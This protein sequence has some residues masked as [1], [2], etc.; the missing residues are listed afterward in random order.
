MTTKAPKT[1]RSLNLP[2]YGPKRFLKINPR[3]IGSNIRVGSF[4][5]VTLA[6]WDGSWT[7]D[8]FVY[9]REIFQDFSGSLR[10]ILFCHKPNKSRHIAAFMGKIED[11]LKLKN[12]SFFGPTQRYNVMWIMPSQWWM[13]REIKRSL[14]TCLLRCGWSYDPLRNNFYEAL[15]SQQYTSETKYAVQRFLRGYT[16]YTGSHNYAYDQRIGWHDT[17][18]WGGCRFEEDSPFAAAL[19]KNEINKLLRKPDFSD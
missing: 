1:V 14:F 7:A 18:R 11:K 15:W 2:N 6:A 13:D 4:S 10:R 19:S 17:F 5:A 8:E 9:C 16:R 3:A 12:R